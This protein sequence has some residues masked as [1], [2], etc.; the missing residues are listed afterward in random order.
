LRARRLSTFAGEREGWPTLPH[1]DRL[2]VCQP[3]FRFCVVAAD[4]TEH[5]WVSVAANTRTSGTSAPYSVSR[6]R[7]AG[8]RPGLSVTAKFAKLSENDAEHCRPGPRDR[9][10][11]RCLRDFQD[12]KEGADVQGHVDEEG[13]E[14]A[15]EEA[16]TATR[17]TALG[18]P[19][20]GLLR[21]RSATWAPHRFSGEPRSGGSRG[22]RETALHEPGERAGARLS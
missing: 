21:Q 9:L 13:S 2:C 3:G 19:A 7:G 8:W 12:P 11:D 6:F 5:R 1:S 14:E 20:N 10:G 17:V 22:P 15:K 16:V 4:L 18:S